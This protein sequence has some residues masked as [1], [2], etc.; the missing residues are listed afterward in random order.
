M[1][2][3]EYTLKP[4]QIPQI[5]E[6]LGISMVLEVRDDL[7]G[8]QTVGIE[9]VAKGSVREQMVQKIRGESLYL[10]LMVLEDKNSKVWQL[11]LDEIYEILMS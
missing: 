2:T 5:L 11:P 6:C 4:S 3:I 10:S 8:N 7:D 1:A 9:L